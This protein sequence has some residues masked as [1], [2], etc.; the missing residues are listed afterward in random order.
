LSDKITLNEV[1]KACKDCDKTLPSRFF[2][3]TDPLGYHPTQKTAICECINA[4]NVV[5]TDI[6]FEIGCGFP[7]FTFSLS[8][9][10][11]I[12]VATDIDE[13]YEKIDNAFLSKKSE[14]IDKKSTGNVR[15][16][17]ST[18]NNQQLK[19]N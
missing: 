5:N 13:V 9:K 3:N 2:N 7:Y 15:V 8:V 19:L 6:C 12:V 4:M 1:E 16:T 18:S 11:A 14:S 10:A 17:K